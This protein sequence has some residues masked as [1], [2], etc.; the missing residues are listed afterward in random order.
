MIVIS[1]KSK[2][3]ITE[4]IDFQLDSVDLCRLG[5]V[6]LCVGDYAVITARTLIVNDLGCYSLT[7]TNDLIV[8]GTLYFGG[9]PLDSDYSGEIK[10]G[11]D[12]YVLGGIM[13]CYN[14]IKYWPKDLINETRDAL[15][16]WG[17]KVSGNIKR[18][19]EEEDY[20]S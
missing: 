7:C 2:I 16:D 10:V 1:K 19:E 6:D 4:D 11:G 8:K 17:I 18:Y 20:K 14:D 3:C 13:D 5:I 15:E 9:D 12:L